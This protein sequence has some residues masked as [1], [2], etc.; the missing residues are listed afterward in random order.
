MSFDPGLDA[1]LPA[2]V[3]AQLRGSGWF[4]SRT[5][6]RMRLMWWRH[7]LQ[8]RGFHVNNFAM[9]ILR[10]FGSLRE[11]PL[12]FG[13]SY[14]LLFDDPDLDSAIKTVSGILHQVLCPFGVFG[15]AV[16]CVSENRSLYVF[17]GRDQGD[18]GVLDLEYPGYSRI[19]D[20][21]EI[22]IVVHRVSV[23]G[24][25]RGWWTMNGKHK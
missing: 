9:E 25:H 15:G 2:D 22:F 23:H 21:A 7:R 11:Y 24:D 13:P 6:C 19:D 8:R 18:G 10:E 1:K 20:F 5:V 12:I 4:P 17:D 3:I 14:Q 16:F